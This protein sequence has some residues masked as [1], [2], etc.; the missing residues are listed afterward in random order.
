MSSSRVPNCLNG[1]NLLAN[2]RT[3]QYYCLVCNVLLFFKFGDK[4]ETSYGLTEFLLSIS[5]RFKDYEKA[6]N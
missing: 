5:L 4:Y 3:G 2:K 6:K 1:G